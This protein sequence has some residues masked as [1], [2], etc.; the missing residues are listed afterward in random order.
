[1]AHAPIPESWVDILDKNV[2]HRG[3]DGTGRYRD[4]TVRKDGATVDVALI[5]TRL[6]VIDIACG[7][8]PMETPSGPKGKGGTGKICVTFNGCIYNHHELRKELAPKGH[9]FKSHHSDTEVLIHGW[10]EWGHEL[11]EHLDGMYAFVIWDAEFGRITMHR[12]RSGEKPCYYTIMDGGRTIVFCSTIPGVIQ[13]RQAAEPGWKPG[14]KRDVIVDW[15]RLGWGETLPLTGVDEIGPRQSVTFPGLKDSSRVEVVH[16]VKVPDHRESTASLTVDDMDRIISESVRSR[17]DSDVPVGCFLSGGIDSSLLAYYAK[18]HLGKLSTICVRFPDEKYDES[19]YADE[20]AKAIGTDH[21]VIDS[22]PDAANDLMYLMR[23]LGLPFGDSS[24]LPA[25]WACRAVK[26]FVTVSLSGDGG[27]ELCYGHERHDKWFFIQK[28]RAFLPMVP[29]RFP[30]AMTR[31]RS[32]VARMSRLSESLKTWGYRSMLSWQLADVLRILPDDADRFAG[33]HPRFDTDPS[34]DDFF[35][36]LP[37]NLLRKADTA[38]MNAPIEVRSP[39]LSNEM[40]DRCLREPISALRRNGEP[41]GILRDLAR[42]YFSPTITERP[43]HGFGVPVGK[44]FRNDFGGLGTLLRDSLA[45]PTPFGAV[46]QLVEI[47]VNQVRGMVDEHMSGTREHST[48]L[49]SLL[50]LAIWAQSLK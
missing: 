6:S 10:R 9:H 2:T 40:I 37:C 24:I 41:K 15:V 19:I 46:Q 16:E 5:H 11:A 45:G 31:G 8:Q 12:D 34:R 50:S 4:S 26:E 21:R 30:R 13:V 14:L 1:M 36:Y 22:H 49:F 39:L 38:C 3:P 29:R 48:R 18:Q 43:K 23:T 35:A 32:S 44:F 28:F 7:A 42:R 27:D 20:V 47:D 33:L 25:F 17:L